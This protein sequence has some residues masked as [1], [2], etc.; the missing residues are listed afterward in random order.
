[1]DT[2]QKSGVRNQE[3]GDV[4]PHETSEPTLEDKTA[5]ESRENNPQ[6]EHVTPLALGG[7]N[8]VPHQ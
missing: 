3:K 7:E 2:A 6:G 4:N 8:S 5:D 1:M